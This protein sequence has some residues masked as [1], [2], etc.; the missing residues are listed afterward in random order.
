MFMELENSI[1]KHELC[2]KRQQTYGL[3]PFKIFI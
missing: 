3:L 2:K 1:K